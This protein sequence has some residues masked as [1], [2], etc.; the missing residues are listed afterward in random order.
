MN[1]G[2]EDPWRKGFMHARARPSVV[3]N[4][5]SAFRYAGSNV[6]V[7]SAK[8]DGNFVKNENWQY[9]KR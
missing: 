3:S 9:S 6:L 4:G 2:N 8:P 7:V 1:P 5:L